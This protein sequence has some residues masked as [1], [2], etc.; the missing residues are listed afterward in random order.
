[1]IFEEEKKSKKIQK[2][3]YAKEAKT[4]DSKQKRENRN[5]INKIKNISNYLDIKKDDLVLEIGGGTGIHSDFLLKNNK[6]VFSL[7][8]SDLSIDMILQ[9]KKRIDKNERISFLVLEGE[10]LPFP[11]D[12]FDKVF[13]SG[14][15]HHFFDPQKGISEFLRV[16][17]RKGRLCV[18]EPNYFFPTNF[19]GT[20][21]RI[22][23]RGIKNMTRKKLSD[24]LSS[25]D[26]EF[27]IENFAYTPPFPKFMINFWDLLD[28]FLGKLPFVSKLSIMIFLRCVKL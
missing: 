9:A 17:K 3:F 15:L 22:E 21:S 24:W 11:N 1:M 25:Q 13:V 16:L 7:I 19:W 27:T 5:H 12:C 10:R 28:S 2:D 26:V 6:V 23:E 14:A 8:C 18:M 4:F 20:W